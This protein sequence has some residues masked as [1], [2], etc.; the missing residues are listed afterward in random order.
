MLFLI[1]FLSSAATAEVGDFNCTAK[2]F[3]VTA[4]GIQEKVEVPMIVDNKVGTSIH[5]TAD[6]GERSYFLSGDL[7]SGD[8]LITQTW[9][10]DGTLGMNATGSFTSTGR[11][12]ISWV[13]GPVVS[14]LECRKIL[15]SDFP[16]E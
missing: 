4:D 5:M 8:F 12:Q 16:N 7:K 2:S 11:M 6:I 14:K 3:K 10:P 13:D 9:G 15:A 1:A